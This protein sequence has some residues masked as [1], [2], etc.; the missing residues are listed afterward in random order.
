MAQRPNDLWTC[1][2]N[3]GTIHQC[4][5]RHGVELV[6]DRKMKNPAN[7]M[8]DRALYEALNLGLSFFEEPAGELTSRAEIDCR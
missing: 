1:S 4:G 2:L 3:V 7:A 5:L 8:A 6:N